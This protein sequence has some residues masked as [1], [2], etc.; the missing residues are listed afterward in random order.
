MSFYLS[1]F[2]VYDYITVSCAY[3]KYTIS[4]ATCLLI[5]IYIYH[6]AHIDV[7]PICAGE[8]L[9]N[10]P[11]VYMK[12]GSH[13]MLPESLNRKAAIANVNNYIQKTICVYIYI[14]I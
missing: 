12:T 6:I 1:I 3:H 4:S 5:R 10:S 9:H 14:Y 2:V 8:V 11:L 13:R 7:G